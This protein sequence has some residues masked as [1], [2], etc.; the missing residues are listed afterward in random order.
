MRILILVAALFTPMTQPVSVSVTT[1][2]T[3]AEFSVG[4]C[5]SMPMLQSVPVRNFK[6]V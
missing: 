5:S 2:F 6:V 1:V 3:C 4:K